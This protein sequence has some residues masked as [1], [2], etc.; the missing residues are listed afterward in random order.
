MTSALDALEQLQELSEAMLRAAIEQNWETLASRETERR[1]LAD[2]LP[3]A[4]GKQSTSA[5]QAR[6]R[7]LIETCLHCDAR[8]R[9]LVA[10]RMN[11]LRVLLRESPAGA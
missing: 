9:P 11:E 1:A 6:A 3:D 2:T 4:A 7:V 5:E 10:T 8:I